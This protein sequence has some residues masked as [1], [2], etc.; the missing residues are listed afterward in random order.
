MSD[1][2]QT[3]APL[4]VAGLVF[5]AFLLKVLRSVVEYYVLC[6]LVEC[7]VS[8]YWVFC[9]LLLDVLCPLVECFVTSY[10]MFCVLLL[11]VLCS[12]AVIQICS[13]WSVIFF[14]LACPKV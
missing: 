6:P 11:E 9:V 8:S 4:S 7:F 2:S 14:S 12:V 13:L 10:W 3:P 5:C 1:S